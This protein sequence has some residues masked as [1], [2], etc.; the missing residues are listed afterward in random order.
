[1][2]ARSIGSSVGVAVLGAAFNA[3]GGRT[4]H[5]PALMPAIRWVLVGTSIAAL[6][7]VVFAVMMPNDRPAARAAD[8]VNS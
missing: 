3:N 5:G 4:L 1:M 6:L 2:F 7:A 8:E